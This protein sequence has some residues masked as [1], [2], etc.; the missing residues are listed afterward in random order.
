MMSLSFV[1]SFTN[2]R[3]QC[4]FDAM[5]EKVAGVRHI[6]LLRIIG[7]VKPDYNCGLKVLY[8]D[9][10]MKTDEKSGL[11]TNQWEGRANRSAPVCATRRLMTFESSRIMCKTMTIGPADKSNYFC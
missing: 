7:L 3:W 10:L 8:V 11:S 4:A 5:L 9:R 2:K 6:H 1:Y